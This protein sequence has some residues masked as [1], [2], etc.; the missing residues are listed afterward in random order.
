MK[1]FTICTYGIWTVVV[2]ARSLEYV[3]KIVKFMYRLH[4]LLEIPSR[5]GTDD[6]YEVF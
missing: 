5:N 6:L 1:E 2:V 4:I 3:P